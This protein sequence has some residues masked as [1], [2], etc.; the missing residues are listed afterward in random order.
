[1]DPME[2]NMQ[3]LKARL[4]ISH[5]YQFL[6]FHDIMIVA[7]AMDQYFNGDFWQRFGHLCS[8]HTNEA[9]LDARQY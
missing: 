5:V 6:R 9:S 7:Q 1:M 8:L 2:Y 3:I 4:K